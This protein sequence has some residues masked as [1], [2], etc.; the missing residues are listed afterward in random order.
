MVEA[1]LVT[2]LLKLLV[3]TTTL[4]DSKTEIFDFE[5]E[6][7]TADGKRRDFEN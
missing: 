5:I 6:P 4:L 7:E 2:L 1:L 3:G